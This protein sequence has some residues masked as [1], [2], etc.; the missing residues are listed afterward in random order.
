[1]TLNTKV[2]FYFTQR[3]ADADREKK[4]EFYSASL[5]LVQKH[6]ICLGSYNPLII[7]GLWFCSYFDTAQTKD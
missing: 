3:H 4:E 5:C 2:A 1:M 6:C 7:N